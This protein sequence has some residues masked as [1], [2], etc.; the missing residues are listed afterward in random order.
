MF[1]FL[2]YLQP[3][4]YYRLS[5]NTDVPV[6]A[7]Y[8]KLSTQ[9]QSLITWDRLYDDESISLM[10]AAYQ[11]LLK[12]IIP[13]PEQAIHFSNN[14]SGSIEHNYRFIRKYFANYWYF[15]VFIIRI[16]SF[17]NPIRE[18]RGF[19]KG[20]RVKKESVYTNAGPVRSIERSVLG[21]PLISVIIPTLNRYKYL[22]DVFKDLE[23]QDY[24]NFE[25]LICDQSEHIPP[26]FYEGRK[27]DIR[28][29]TQLDKALWKA[30]NTLIAN[31]KGDYIALFDDD[32]RIEANWL[33]EHLRCVQNYPKSLSAG[34]THTLNGHGLSPREEYYHLSEVFDTGNAM[35]NK[36]VFEE[37]GLFDRQFE[38]QR[39]GD[40]EFGLRAF[41]G[42]YRIIA[43]PIA[44]RVH[45]KGATGGL[46]QMGSWDAFNPPTLFSPRPIPSTLYLA[47]KYFGDT[48]AIYLLLATVPR[49]LTPYR[50]KKNKLMKWAGLILLPL[51]LPLVL[52]QIRKSWVKSGQKL[53]QGPIIDTLQ[54]S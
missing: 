37:V 26:D 54:N 29:F 20:L 4:W 48:S 17:N 18:F 51:Y 24:S 32:S 31:A 41:L 39:M 42:G 43:N 15:F 53:T 6:F 46:R 10:D 2:K 34:I 5:P 49:T 23:N 28:L 9:E 47:R 7:D 1:Y 27:L 52:F 38:K 44:K 33:S 13:T 16:L 19:L 22:E 21:T 50:F 35:L 45:L 12:G 14:A 11:G 8:R 40:G 36:K 25:V 30:R 3:I